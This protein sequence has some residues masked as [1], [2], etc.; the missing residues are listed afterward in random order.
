MELCGEPAHGGLLP[1]A[2]QLT[3]FMG[4]LS[5]L[6]RPVGG[7]EGTRSGRKG[8]FMQ[9]EPFSFGKVSLGTILLF[10]NLVFHRPAVLV[11]QDQNPSRCCGELAPG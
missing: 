2:H 6:Q 5:V 1:Q 8:K 3:W 4:G 9:K 10:W 7:R 11:G